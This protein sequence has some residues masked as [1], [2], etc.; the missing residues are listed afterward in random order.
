M[1]SFRQITHQSVLVSLAVILVAGIGYTFA[2]PTAPPPG[3]AIPL[4]LHEG[5]AAQTK[6]G[7]LT[8][9]GALTVNGSATLGTLNVSEICLNG[10]CQS[11]W[12]SGGGFSGTTTVNGAAYNPGY[13][14]GYS[15]YEQLTYYR[16][17][18]LYNQNQYNCGTTN[19]TF[20]VPSTIPSG[21]VAGP[22]MNGTVW[23]H[24]GSNN[25]SS[26]TPATTYVT[27]NYYNY[28][29]QANVTSITNNNNGSV[30]IA[31]NC[32]FLGGTSYVYMGMR[33]ENLQFFY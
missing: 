13:C 7:A 28:R 1:A 19:F 4:P 10:D 14:S 18:S 17:G 9:Q 23:C 2:A 11:E 25:Y 8:V 30:T 6:A 24:G 12:P 32:K 5:S 16:N 33:A 15:F 3:T 21:E 22:V 31:G 29:I 26:Y 20:S 27:D